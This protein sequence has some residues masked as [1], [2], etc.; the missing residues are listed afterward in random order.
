MILI[1]GYIIDTITFFKKT[2]NLYPASF[3]KECKETHHGMKKRKNQKYACN[4]DLYSCY[5][6]A[7]NL[8]LCCL[9][10]GKTLEKGKRETFIV[11]TILIL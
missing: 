2:G 7:V 9:E 4:K 3:N 10:K 1:W 11:A 8:D 6:L 5:S